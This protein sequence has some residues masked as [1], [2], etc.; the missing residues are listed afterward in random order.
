M[1]LLT[2]LDIKV[3]SHQIIVICACIVVGTS[4]TIHLH[5]HYLFVGSRNIIFHMFEKARVS[6]VGFDQIL[7]LCRNKTAKIICKCSWFLDLWDLGIE[8]NAIT[9]R[10]QQLSLH[11]LQEQLPS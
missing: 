9:F 8:Q 7:G 11:L 3:H 6:S 5:L 1:V 2:S 10:Q 4:H